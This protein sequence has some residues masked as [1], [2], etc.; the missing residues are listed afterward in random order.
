M[1]VACLS[2]QALMFV[3]KAK[4]RVC[5]KNFYTNSNQVYTY[6]CMELSEMNEI[7]FNGK[8]KGIQQYIFFVHEEKLF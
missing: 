4:T 1:P 2:V 7:T 3:C 8:S 5:K 6:V